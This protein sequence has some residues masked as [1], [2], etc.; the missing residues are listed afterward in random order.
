MSTAWRGV[1][2]IPVTPFDERGEVD[3]DSLRRCVEFCV[4]AGAHGVVAPVNASE[5]PLLSESERREVTRV[6]VEAASARVPVVAGVSAMTA[7]ES[8]QLANYAREVGADAVIAMPPYAK[9]AS[10]D[11]IGEFYRQVA[12]V[13]L[14]VFVQNFAGPLGTPL[15]A[16]GVA[17]LVREIDGVGYVKEETL[18]AGHT[19]TALFELLGRGPGGSQGD[20]QSNG[21][22]KGIMGGMAGRYMLDEFR[23]GACGTMPACEVTD[24]HV[25]IW[26]ALESGDLERAR[27]LHTRLLPL[28]NVESLFGAAIYKEVLRRRGVIACSAMRGPG[29]LSLDRFDQQ[30]LDAILAG[31]S[32]LFR[33]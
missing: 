28:L 11:E 13:G 5:A 31:V 24:V 12:G 6:V 16:A 14:P 2:S 25:Q 21:R 3:L 10:V 19:M 30:E 22:L 4:R 29:A 23:R 33:V 15:S 20:G 9:R 1:F 8:V 32:D 26:D 27:R 18:P 7:R 17:D